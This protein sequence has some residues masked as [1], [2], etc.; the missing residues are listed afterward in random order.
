MEVGVQ[1]MFHFRFDRLSSNVD[2]RCQETK[3]GRLNNLFTFLCSLK[4]QLWLE[5][6]SSSVAHRDVSG[7]CPRLCRIF[8]CVPD[9]YLLDV[10]WLP[11]NFDK[12]VSRDGSGDILS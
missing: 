10:K 4:V 3:N 9:L 8:S 7:V 12:N 1:Q 11:P 6:H 5:Q 2:F